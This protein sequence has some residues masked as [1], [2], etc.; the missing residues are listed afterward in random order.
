MD[1][2]LLYHLSVKLEDQPQD[3]VGGWVLRSE[4][5]ADGFDVF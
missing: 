5:Y 2:H 3:A 1:I 4:V